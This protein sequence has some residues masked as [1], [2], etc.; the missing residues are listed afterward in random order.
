MDMASDFE[1]WVLEKTLTAEVAD[2]L[3]YEASK[4]LD[5]LETTDDHYH[6]TFQAFANLGRAVF[7]LGDR[8]G[9]VD[10]ELRERVKAAL[11]FSNPSEISEE[12][13][14][15]AEIH[16]FVY[17]CAR[18]LPTQIGLASIHCGFVAD[19]VAAELRGRIRYVEGAG[20]EI[21]KNG[22]WHRRPKERGVL[23]IIYD[24]M[25]RK[26]KLWREVLA[27]PLGEGGW[28][29]KLEKNLNDPDW[30]RKVE[31]LLLRVDY[32]GVEIVSGSA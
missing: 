30:L 2:C 12:D 7:I 18:S 27:N 4:R 9:Q 10:H 28:L 24:V 3:V 32:F 19:L 21:W 5:D 20:W 15:I 22:A 1:K 8:F 17:G 25:R 11:S 16:G 14:R 6:E 31:E 13:L 29:E 26:I 23:G